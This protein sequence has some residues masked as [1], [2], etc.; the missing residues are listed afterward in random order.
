MVM[1]EALRGLPSALREGAGFE[2]LKVLMGLGT[3]GLCGTSEVRE[4]A[5]ADS[6]RA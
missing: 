1:R 6:G 4:S 2:W 3:L 5:H